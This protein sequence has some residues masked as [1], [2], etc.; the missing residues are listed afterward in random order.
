MS[1]TIVFRLKID[2]II[3]TITIIDIVITTTIVDIVVDKLNFVMTN[4]CFIFVAI[5]THCTMSKFKRTLKAKNKRS[6]KSLNENCIHQFNSYE[7]VKSLSSLFYD[8]D[9]A[10]L[11]NAYI[12][13]DKKNICYFF[14]T[15][16]RNL[17][18]L[19]KIFSFYWSSAYDLQSTFI[20]F[21][22]I[23]SSRW[24]NR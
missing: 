23:C 17:S 1:K 16:A 2:F 15:F 18:S 14:L 6:I 22:F 19:K 4:M 7:I 9:R 20:K 5:N 8:H 3:V 12:D 11:Q 21:S 13:F 24:E 10:A